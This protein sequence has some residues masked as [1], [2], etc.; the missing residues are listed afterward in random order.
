MIFSNMEYP[1]KNYRVQV[2]DAWLGEELEPMDNPKDGDKIVYRVLGEN[3]QP[4]E[5]KT[6][7][8]QNGAWVEQG[9]GGSSE[10]VLYQGSF[11]TTQLKPGFYAGPV[12]MY[13]TIPYNNPPVY[14]KAE[15]N[16][17]EYSLP[18]ADNMNMI[19]GEVNAGVPVFTTFPITLVLAGEGD[20]A[21]T[22][23]IVTQAAETNT[24]KV[25]AKI[26]SGGGSVSLESLDVTA[27]GDYYADEGKGWDEVHVAVVPVVPSVSMG[28]LKLTNQTGVMLYAESFSVT[29]GVL[30]SSTSEPIIISN[31]STKNVAVPL[32]SAT[33]AYISFDLI[34]K[35]AT[36]AGDISNL[37]CTVTAPSSSVPGSDFSA[38]VHGTYRPSDPGGT[39][40][41][42]IVHFYGFIPNGVVPEMSVTLT[43]S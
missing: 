21:D 14:I 9:G 23:M 20:G 38:I 27:N 8:Y 37:A 17:E 24:I 41:R 12:T 28:K 43:L 26:S 40:M 31:N 18:L 1:G 15:Y 3:G 39:N 42:A 33:T 35:C 5:Q 22:L 36:S 2:Y 34:L 19:Y 4:V 29:D 6:E 10:T 13:E 11:T 25:S 16:G 32:A 30:V 7:V